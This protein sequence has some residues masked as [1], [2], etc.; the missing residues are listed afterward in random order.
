M[1]KPNDSVPNVSPVWTHLLDTPLVRGQ[2][3]YVW[4][5]TGR[6]Y[7]DFTSGIGVVNTGHSHPRV[8]AAVREQA[9]L[10]LH[11]QAN[12][13]FVHEPMLRL[14]TALKEIVPPELDTFFFSNSGAE[15]VE[16]A[17]KLARQATRRPNVIAFQRWDASGNVI[18]VVASFNNNAFYNYQIGVPQEGTWYELIN[19]QAAGYEGSGLNNGG[20]IQTSWDDY[21]GFDQSV[22]LTLPGMQGRANLEE[23]LTVINIQLG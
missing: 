5:S 19:S 11:L 7:L 10:G 9:G 22:Y 23:S 17:V 2:G 18:V 21:D 8:V 6:R 1:S 12:I 14:I 16:A 13:G 20:G 3:A 4:D 15:A